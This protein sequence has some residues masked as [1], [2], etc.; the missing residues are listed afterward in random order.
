MGR[1][2]RQNYSFSYLYNDIVTNNIFYGQSPRANNTNYGNV[3]NNNLAYGSSNNTLPPAASGGVNN[4]GTGNIED[5]V[6]SFVNAELL[7]T[8]S[9][10]YDYTLNPGS[11]AL[12]GSAQNPSS[13]DI[14]IT[15]G[16]FALT[17]STIN[18]QLDTSPMPTIEAFNTSVT[19][20]PNDDLPVN[21]K[22]K[23][24]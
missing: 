24:N 3:F 9:S 14:G 8:W 17:G 11:P 5:L 16:T 15:G 10:A 23:G 13:E 4:T 1:I 21:I 22:A 20:N 18:F 7:N 12:A 2:P 6:P 19:I